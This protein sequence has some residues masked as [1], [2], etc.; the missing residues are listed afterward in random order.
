MNL[1][2]S[3]CH[4]WNLGTPSAA[5][6]FCSWCGSTLFEIEVRLA[7]DTV[8]LP[9][10]NAHPAKRKS[11]KP[12][13]RSTAVP[14][15]K[16]LVKNNGALPVQI[17]GLVSSPVPCVHLAPQKKAGKKAPAGHKAQRHPSAGRIQI[18][19]GE[20]REVKG[21][22][23]LTKLRAAMRAPAVSAETPP[24]KQEAAS[25]TK[26]YQRQAPDLEVWQEAQVPA[27]TT[28]VSPELLKETRAATP[29]QSLKLQ[30]QLQLSPA[31]RAPVCEL[32]VLPPPEF[33]WLTPALHLLPG[34]EA[35]TATV[36]CASPASLRLRQGAVRI[37]RFESTHAG[38]LFTAVGQNGL[39]VDLQAGG[40]NVIHFQ[41]EVA[42][43]VMAVCRRKDRP[44]LA[45][46]KVICAAP[47]GVFQPLPA[48]LQIMPRLLANLAFP[49]FAGSGQPELKTW[50][51]AGRVRDLPVRV[52][53]E[54]DQILEIHAVE[55]TPELDLLMRKSPALPMRLAP[56]EIATFHFMLDMRT[57]AV[58]ANIQGLVAFR[59]RAEETSHERAVQFALQVETR[60]PSAFKGAAALDF[61]TSSSCVA[62]LEHDQRAA[63]LLDIQGQA[64]V[65]TA[66]IY[67]R[68]EEPERTYDIG[69]AAQPSRTASGQVLE[70]F[71]KGFS[72]EQPRVVLPAQAAAPI[73]LTNGT[74][75]S[76]YLRGLLRAAEDRLA[77]ELFQRVRHHPETDFGACVL[78]RVLLACPATF[79]FQQKQTLRQVLTELEVQVRADSFQSA[80][81][82]SCFSGLGKMLS[83]WENES[84]SV[85][86]E[87]V[88]TRHVLV[89]DLGA[90]FTDMAL[91]RLEIAAETGKTLG[92][93]EAVKIQSKIL[94]V[95]GDD[96]FGGQSVTA[97]A[98]KSLAQQ[99][100]ARLERKLHTR[101]HL[102]LWYH[103]GAAPLKAIEQIGFWNWRQLRNGAEQAKRRLA[104]DAARAE[105]VIPRLVLQILVDRKLQAMTVEQLR[106]RTDFV[107]KV[108]AVRLELH[109]RKMQKLLR[110][111]GLE[112]PD[113]LYLSGRSAALPGIYRIAARAL[114]CRVI[115]AGGD[116]FSGH[117]S[118]TSSLSL[119]SL[120]TS[121]ALGG[122][123]YARLLQYEGTFYKESPSLKS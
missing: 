72:H 34:H 98:A 70:D 106:L 42:N 73:L 81:A 92:T 63:R 123:Q 13:N 76:D 122:A 41:V 16:L 46:L 83:L 1:I 9:P 56:Q 31:G 26:A 93:S 75:A 29:L 51:L 3:N 66:L 19:P 37:S 14:G 44:L 55:A 108:I 77:E 47:T 32:T 97:A 22:F 79:T 54:G 80:A 30:L 91:V 61:G 4:S 24:Q 6:K 112:T 59:F 118:A 114:G 17:V 107:E 52:R 69:L 15:F 35:S 39:P 119:Q 110:E 40:E 84:P 96:Q 45:G 86:A 88:L 18:A 43:E 21:Q 58:A 94:G 23:H 116:D 5:D 20:S 60:L 87:T 2:C 67:H 74:I 57:V 10:D 104:A 36:K 89:Y 111:A 78:Q 28:S 121:V 71:K 101:P 105:V 109:L 48:P 115:F 25:P 103:A 85:A 100:L 11:L 65:P 50:G 95:D 64:L 82:M 113:L 27:A 38:V 8:Y 90:A 120:K 12:K 33:E 7:G 49:D 99:T 102:P 62:V 53:N 68:V 117:S